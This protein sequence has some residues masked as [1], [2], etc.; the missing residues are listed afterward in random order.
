MIDLN[1][2][3]GNLTNGDGTWTLADAYGISENGQY[4]CGSATNGTV[5]HGF[6]LTLAPVPEPSTLLLVVS[7]LVGLLAYAW[8]RRR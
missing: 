8:R 7:G 6:L 1:S 5:T 2:L 3:V 4:I